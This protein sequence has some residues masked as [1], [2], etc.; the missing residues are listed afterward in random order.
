MRDSGAPVSVAGVP[1]SDTCKEVVDG[2][3]RRT[4]PRENLVTLTGPWLVSREALTAALG[5]PATGSPRD[6]LELFR[7]SGMAIHVSPAS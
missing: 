1:V 3:V 2:V 4:V 6:P 7:A 5:R